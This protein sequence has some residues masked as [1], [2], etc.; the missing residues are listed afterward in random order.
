MST[1]IRQYFSP[2]NN[3]PATGTLGLERLQ[4]ANQTEVLEKQASQ[5]SAKKRK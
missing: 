1:G 5:Q 3:F 4:L 2:T